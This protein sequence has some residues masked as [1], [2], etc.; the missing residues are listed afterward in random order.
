MDRV[1]E[2][3]VGCLASGAALAVGRN[4]TALDAGE[5]GER[6]RLGLWGDPDGWRYDETHM[7]S[8]SGI[9]PRHLADLSGQRCEMQV[10]ECGKF[11]Q[12]AAQQ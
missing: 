10:R 2:L 11:A 8:E 12:R 7:A 3:V 9:T 4:S 1:D 6:P 5:R